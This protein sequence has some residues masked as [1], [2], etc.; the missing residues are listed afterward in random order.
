MRNYKHRSNSGF[1]LVETVIAMGIIT[2]MITAFMAAFGPAV[3]G[4]SRSISAKEVNRLASTLE[5]ELSVLRPDEATT[6]TTAFE[7]AFTWI[8][9]SGGTTKPDMLLMY[10]YRG[11]PTSPNSDGTLAPYTEKDGISGKNYILQ[12]VV[13]Q[14]S[15]TAAVSAE[16]APGVLEGRVFIVKM[17][18][19]V[20][21][22][23]ALE[24]TDNPMVIQDPQTPAGGVTY[25]LYP[26][27]TIA[28]QA[29]FYALKSSNYNYIKNTF[30]LNTTR[31]DGH[32]DK[33][34]KPIFVRNMAVRR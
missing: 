6:Y 34:G 21:V 4:I 9:A 31:T 10:Q 20:F 23:G 5:Y 28:F 32:P 15:N 14:F 13:R 7:K 2:I 29:S 17:S 8:A 33:T 11:D 1:T 27:A 25:A 26:E 30:D 22:N 3:K 24:V 18:Q 12:S 16:L 19:L